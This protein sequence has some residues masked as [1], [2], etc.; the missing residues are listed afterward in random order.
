MDLTVTEY[1]FYSSVEAILTDMPASD[2]IVNI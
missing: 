2:N 1:E